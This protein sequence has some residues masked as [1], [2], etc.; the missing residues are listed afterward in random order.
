[1]DENVKSSLETLHNQLSGAEVS[2]AGNQAHLDEVRQAVRESIDNPDSAHPLT[3]RERLEK[4]S[5]VFDAEHPG[6]ATALHTAIN[7]LADAGF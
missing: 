3:L 1:M 7:V 6:V 5:A 4:A 2:G